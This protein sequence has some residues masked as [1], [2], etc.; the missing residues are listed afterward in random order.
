M[1]TP[2][3]THNKL[4]FLHPLHGYSDKLSNSGSSKLQNQETRFGSKKPLVKWGRCSGLRASSSAL[5]ELVPEIKKENLDF[6]LPLYDS[7]KG[8]VVD[9]AAE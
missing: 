5:L 8:A 9:L 1:D 4:E 6:E 3:K 7:S 2:L